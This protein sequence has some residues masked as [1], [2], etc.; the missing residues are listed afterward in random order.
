MKLLVSPFSDC[1]PLS[2]SFNVK[3]S[4]LQYLNIDKKDITLDEKSRTQG[5]EIQ[6]D[7]SRTLEINK[8][9]RVENQENPGGVLIAE[10]FTRSYLSDNRV[11]CFLRTYNYHR[12]AEGYLYIKD[13]D[14]A[15]FIS[16]FNI[17]PAT[18]ISQMQVMRDGGD[19]NHDLSV[20]PGETISVKI[21]GTALI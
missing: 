21:E 6:I 18:N 8:T 20:Y 5:V 16:N 13:G 2:T 12:S 9:Y 1:H 3:T 4:R 19:W 10:I 14:N 17:T 11:L 15:R 7:N